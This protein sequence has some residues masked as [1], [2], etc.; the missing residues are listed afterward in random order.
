MPITFL[1]KKKIQRAL[2][3]VL[4]AVVLVTASVVWWGFFLTAPAPQDG[5]VPQPR[6]VNVDTSILS[7]PVLQELDEPRSKVQV[8]EEVGRDNPLLPAP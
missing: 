2:I 3:L 1:E 5:M 6:R 4:G 7:H 8:P